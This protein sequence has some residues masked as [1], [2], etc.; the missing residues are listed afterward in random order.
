MNLRRRS[1]VQSI[2]AIG[3][4]IFSCWSAP[5]AEAERLVI[6]ASPTV[7]DP[8]EALSRAFEAT[9]PDVQVQLALATGLAMRQT[10]ATI[11]N[12]G[13]YFIGTGPIHLVAPGGDELL[14]RLGRKYY[15]LPETGVTYAT[16]P[17]VLVV[18]ESLV[19]A[20]TSFESLAD[21]RDLRIAIAD[22]KLTTLG[23]QTLQL[24]Q[25]LDV[26]SRLNDRYDVAADAPAVLD[27]LLHGR[28]DVAIV[29]GPD[30]VRER[31]RIRVVARA[32]PPDSTAHSMAMSRSCPNRT[33]CE[34]FL[35]FL[36]SVDARKVLVEH[37]YQPLLVTP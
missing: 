11:E 14:G 28:A 31:E 18:P 16:V 19:E 17:L 2:F 20:P 37:G 13:P 29:Y 35:T 12:R 34:Q 15:V 36:R 25:P 30:A 7:L 23:R 32:N 27:H 24:L 33:L 5:Y 22:P 9:H 3:I 10:I 4:A 6:A 21:K 1:R 26:T 8:V